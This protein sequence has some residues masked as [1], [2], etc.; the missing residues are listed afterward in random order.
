MDALAEVDSALADVGLRKQVR[1]SLVP[2]REFA[3][4]YDGPALDKRNVSA[5]IAPIAD[6]HRLSFSV[7][8]EES[9]SFP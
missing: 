4:T 1:S 9:V 3:L 2:G 7:E 5:I 8:A 6:R